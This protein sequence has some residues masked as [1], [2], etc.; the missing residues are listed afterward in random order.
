[1]EL[2]PPSVNVRYFVVYPMVW[3]EEDPHL[4]DSAPVS[5]ATAAT[6]LADPTTVGTADVYSFDWSYDEGGSSAGG[7]SLH[8]GP[9]PFSFGVPQLSFACDSSVPDPRPCVGVS[10]SSFASYA[11]GGRN[12]PM[13]PD[14]G[15]NAWLVEVT[16]TD[17]S[18]FG[19]DSSALF[20]VECGA[21]SDGGQSVGVGTSAYAN[22]DPWGT[23]VPL[24]DVLTRLQFWRIPTRIWPDDPDPP[25]N[26]W[27]SFVGSHEII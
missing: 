26:F 21:S 20:T 7:A 25:P 1:M 4:G 10:F 11:G 27:T 2:S 19:V 18:G 3:W 12:V 6:M 24:Q 5:R 22:G 9:G 14:G 17:A 8:S 16:A 15:V 13:D 23:F